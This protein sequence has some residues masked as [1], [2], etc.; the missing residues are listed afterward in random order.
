MA[1]KLLKTGAHDDLPG[2]SLLL[3]PKSVD[4]RFNSS[5]S[6]LFWLQSTWNISPSN[7]TRIVFEMEGPLPLRETWEKFCQLI[8]LC[9]GQSVCCFPSVFRPG[10]HGTVTDP[11]HFCDVRWS[12]PAH[13]PQNCGW[14]ASKDLGENDSRSF[15]FIWLKQAYLQ[16]FADFNIPS[17]M[18]IHFLS[19][20]HGLKSSPSQILGLNWIKV[21]L[22]K[23]HLMLAQIGKFF[24]G[25]W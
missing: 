12:G 21:F 23:I 18:S 17:T 20:V 10:P 14:G 9:S 1:D 7:R 24:D 13:L 25:T 4:P 15:T 16:A 5:N 2:I 6:I 19:K 11:R 3:T 22:G 8:S